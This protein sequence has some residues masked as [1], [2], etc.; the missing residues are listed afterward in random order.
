MILSRFNGKLKGQKNN[1]ISVFFFGY[2]NEKIKTG[3]SNTRPLIS[4]SV[5][6]IID[7]FGLGND[8][9]KIFRFCF[10]QIA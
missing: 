8:H 10:N 3:V 4:T 7:F 9:Q 2:P 5:F 1:E 6:A